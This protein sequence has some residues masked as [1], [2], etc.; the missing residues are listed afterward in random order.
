LADQAVTVISVNDCIEIKAKE[1][2]VLQA[3][4]SSITLDGGNIT[5]ACP[6][7]FTV[8]GG[9]HLFDGGVASSAKLTALPD[10]RAKIYKERFRAI[11][12]VTKKPISDLPYKIELQDGAVMTGRTDSDG[13]TEQVATADPTT[14]KVF[15]NIDANAENENLE[16]IAMR[17]G[18]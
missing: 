14:V 17:E 1:K 3:G 7:K 9:Q 10:S 13:N 4:Q 6:G 11:D 2:V 5:F 15:W 16:D 12:H 8:K 18:C